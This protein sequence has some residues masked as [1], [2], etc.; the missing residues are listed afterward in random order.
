MRVI[1]K[2]IL[3]RSLCISIKCLFIST[4]LFASDTTYL[5][6]SS[7]VKHGHYYKTAL[8]ISE[9]RGQKISGEL[10]RQYM[11]NPYGMEKYYKTDEDDQLIVLARNGKGIEK[12]E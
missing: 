1:L 9:Y 12:I 11:I 4:V 7:G 2:C 5:I 3:F 6:L 10:K 8:E